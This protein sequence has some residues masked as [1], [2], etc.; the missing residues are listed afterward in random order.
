[1]IN[2][3]QELD[4]IVTDIKSKESIFKIPT[5]YSSEYFPELVETRLEEF[6]KF[7]SD[8]SI[9]K[10]LNSIYRTLE[11]KDSSG[12]LS[13]LTRLR[14][15]IKAIN[16]SV[17]SY[18]DGFTYKAYD[19]FSTSLNNIIEF[20]NN[21]ALSYIEPNQSYYKIRVDESLSIKNREDNF[22]IPFNL[23][24]FCAT[25][26]YSIPGIP[27]IYL[28]STS[29]LSYEELGRPKIASSY[30]SRFETKKLIRIIEIQTIYNFLKFS[31]DGELVEKFRHVLRYLILFPLYFTTTIRV[32]ETGASFKTEYIIPQ[33]LMQFIGASNKDDDA[34]RGVKFPSSKLKY[35]TDDD[36]RH[37]S[38]V[39]PIVRSNKSGF[40]GYLSS[41]FH[42]S[43]PKLISDILGKGDINIP[44]VN[45]EHSDFDVVDNAL[46]SEKVDDVLAV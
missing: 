11:Q 28:G 17:S 33:L 43:K 5:V 46:R 12:D 44:T 18:Y 9:G 26:R 13:L 1:M 4:D 21:V 10:R 20:H 3:S 6:Y 36:H 23:R 29:Y 16:S 27:S 39:F 24:H 34:I 25:Q 37:F 30:I 22:H 15:F 2:A 19:G 35:D 31:N 32:I 40:C 38:Y 42:L 7:L 41:V 45:Y 14:A 8:Y